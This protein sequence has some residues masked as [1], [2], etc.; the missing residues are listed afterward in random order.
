M[1]VDFKTLAEY[2]N[3]RHKKI[4][5]LS[6]LYI[7]FVVYSVTI[8]VCCTGISATTSTSNLVKEPTS[9]TP[10]TSSSFFIEEEPN[11]REHLSKLLLCIIVFILL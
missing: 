10:I 4:V 8:I 9:V 6:V 1:E 5:N 2:K 7:L 3:G 11:E